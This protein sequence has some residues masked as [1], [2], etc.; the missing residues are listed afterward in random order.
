LKHPHGKLRLAIEVSQECPAVHS[1]A[2]DVI[3]G[4]HGRGPFPVAEERH[5]AERFVGAED[6]GDLRVGATEAFDDLNVA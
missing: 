3:Q 5:L 6:S 4:P 2:F 1:K